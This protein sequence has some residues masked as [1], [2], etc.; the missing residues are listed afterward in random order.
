MD[1]RSGHAGEWYARQS[2]RRG[3]GM[4]EKIWVIEDDESV[5]RELTAL[6]QANGYEV[7]GGPPCS[8][9]LLDVNLPGE[10]GFELCRRLRQHSNVP[11]IF[12]T[13]RDSAED[14]IVGFGVGADDY[15][16]KPYHSSVLLA[17]MA[18]LLK[19]RNN[20]VITAGELTLNLAELTVSRDGNVQELTKNE[21]R[22]LACLMKKGLCTREEIIE[23]LWQN[24]LY[25]DENTL[26]VN[27]N[28]LRE[29]LD[30]LGAEGCIR[31]VRGVGY[32]L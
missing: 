14:E 22:I 1:R 16:R 19:S 18:R 27:I 20:P 6:L 21:T 10:N 11:V 4:M 25:I 28:R 30:R 17:R 2:A 8:L 9:A 12:L 15:I 24:S 23:D 26:Y 13:A 31:T 32:R 7:V 5:R 29:K 3:M